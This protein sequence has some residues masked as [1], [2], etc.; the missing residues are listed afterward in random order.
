MLRDGFELMQSSRTDVN[1]DHYKRCIDYLS[2]YGSH[3]QHVL[4]IN[5]WRGLKDAI[6]AFKQMVMS[7]ACQSNQ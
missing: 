6:T 3:Y 1:I 7:L 5:K 4:F 2:R